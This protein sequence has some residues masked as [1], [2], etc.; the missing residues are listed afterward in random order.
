MVRIALAQPHQEPRDIGLGDRG[1]IVDAF[2][3]EEL[4]V[5]AQVPPVRGQGVGCQAAFDAEV[6]QIGADRPLQRRG[7]GR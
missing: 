5:P 2:V 3:P 1:R 4:G 6:V 7:T